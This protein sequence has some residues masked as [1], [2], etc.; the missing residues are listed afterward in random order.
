MNKKIIP[1]VVVILS[2]TFIF[3]ALK[4]LSQDASLSSWGSNFTGYTA[5]TQMQQSSDKPIALYFYT[6]WCSN[7]K[8]LREKI[9]ASAQVSD[10]M[11]NLHAV[12]IN[13]E[14]GFN[15]A[16]LEKKYGVLGYP[17]FFIVLENGAV[18]KEI[19]RTANITPEQF[20]AQL[21][22]AIES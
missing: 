18:I 6:D 8:A 10:F 11:E 16:E 5:A 14:M 20:I 15:E 3:M 17:S 7:C 19:S 2:A 4:N 1:L 21:Q 13:P 12:K 22:Q 9:L